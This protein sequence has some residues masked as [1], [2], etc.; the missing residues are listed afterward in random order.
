MNAPHSRGNTPK[1]AERVITTAHLTRF[2]ELAKI[3]A[4]Q[5]YGS[6]ALSQAGCVG[7]FGFLRIA[8]GNKMSS[9]CQPISLACTRLQK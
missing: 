2:A 8:F 9:C 3:P 6:G 5:R 1:A 7:C 4:G